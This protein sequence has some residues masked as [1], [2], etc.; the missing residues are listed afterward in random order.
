M[1]V[2]SFGKEVCSA[3]HKCQR[4]DAISWNAE[5]CEEVLGFGR[6]EK[7]ECASVSGCRKQGV[8]LPAD[9]SA[10]EKDCKCVGLDFVHLGSCNKQLGVGVVGD[11]CVPLFG[12]S[13]LTIGI[14]SS[15][16]PSVAA[17]MDACGLPFG[18]PP[19]PSPPTPSWPT[20]EDSADSDVIICPG[21]DGKPLIVKVPAGQP[22]TRIRYQTPIVPEG[23]KPFLVSGPSS[24]SFFNVGEHRVVWRATNSA[25]RTVGQC[26]FTVTVVEE[27]A[28]PSSQPTPPPTPTAQDI[29]KTG[30]DTKAPVIVCPGG[31]KSMVKET[32]PGAPGMLITYPLPVA[33]DNEP[34]ATMMIIRGPVSGEFFPIGDTV[35]TY[36]VTDAAGLS[37]ECS[38][39]VTIKEKMPNAPPT[40]STVPLQQATEGVETSIDLSPYFSDPDGDELV[41]FVAD[42]PIGSGFT[43]EFDTG[44]LVGTPSHADAT[45][46]QPL[47]IRVMAGDGIS[48]RVVE[49][50]QIRIQ[51][52]TFNHKPIAGKMPSLTATEGKKF[53]VNLAIYFSDPD[54]M[55]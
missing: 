13:E 9:K 43:I 37:A 47:T 45:A 22:G 52:D 51:P 34:G 44:K 3:Q 17:C 54:G 11:K 10:C 24:E 28:A 42:L 14:S 16:Y 29:T 33:S 5:A 26:E 7:G 4:I 49:K 53:S 21:D 23:I 1:W 32:S 41:Y 15:I 19:T 12:C 48:G 36:K 55:D 50:V 20:P 27:G 46:P 35:V 2:D 31:G 6:N 18:V 30:E 40:S 39:T 38:F 8:D 25:Q